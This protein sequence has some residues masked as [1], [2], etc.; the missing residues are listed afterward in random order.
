MK[1]IIDLNVD[2][3]VIGSAIFESGNARENLN[4]FKDLC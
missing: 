3:I 2:E 4:Y 1:K